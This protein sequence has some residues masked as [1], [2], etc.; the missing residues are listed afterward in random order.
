MSTTEETETPVTP[1]DLLPTGGLVGSEVDAVDETEDDG[2]TE[3]TPADLL[4]VGNLAD[5][6]EVVVEA[7]VEGQVADVEVFDEDA[8]LDPDDSED[9]PKPESA[10]DRP[11]NWFVVHTQSGYENKVCKNL[12]ARTESMNLE[13]RILEIVIPMEDV[14]E[15][16]NGKK[17]TVA[18][19]MF[20]GYL[21]VRCYLDDASWA[22]IRD[23]PGIVNFVGAGGKP[24]RL[25]RREIETFLPTADDTAAEAPVKAKARLGFDT[26]DTVRVKEGPFADFS[27]EII[28]INIDQLKVKVLVNIF[29]RETP[30]ELDF[31]QVAQL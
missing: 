11:G 9:G 27:G 16:K 12:Q 17:V 15:F 23:T 3:P 31:S 21:L 18:K 10:Y 29:G 24:S 14:V 19:K 1:A 7:A 28:E 6:T 20:P 26:G 2:A 30:V 5:E 22:A 4:P 25:S 8:L 13:D